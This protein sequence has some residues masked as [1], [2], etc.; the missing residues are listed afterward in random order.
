MKFSGKIGPTFGWF[1][2]RR[3]EMEIK[4]ETAGKEPKPPE[5]GRDGGGRRKKKEGTTGPEEENCPSQQALV[6]KSYQHSIMGL[7]GI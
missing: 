6:F 3:L 4:P 7:H 5:K 2:I 1:A